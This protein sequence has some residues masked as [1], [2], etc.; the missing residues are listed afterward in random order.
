MR[1]Y[2]AERADAVEYYDMHNPHMRSI[3]R[4]GN[5]HSR[6]KSRFHKISWLEVAMS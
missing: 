4:D 2:F 1:A 6:R 3:D 5:G